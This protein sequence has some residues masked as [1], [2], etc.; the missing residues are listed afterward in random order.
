MKKSFASSLLSRG[1][2]VH[3]YNRT[4]EKTQSL[5]EKGAVFH[6]T[7]RDPALVAD[8]VMT[9]LTF[10]FFTVFLPF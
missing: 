10:L 6:S 7:S 1:Y 9:S 5:I 3:V 2:N 8:L 4:K